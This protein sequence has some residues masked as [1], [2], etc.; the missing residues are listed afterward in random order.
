MTTGTLTQQPVGTPAIPGVVTLI[1][2]YIGL[3]IVDAFA[4]WLIFSL[5]N[6]GIWELAVAIA[7]IT[8][9][10]NV[11]NLRPQLKPL[12]WMSPAFA[13]L[14]LGVIY[15]IVYTV[16]VAFTNYGDGHLLTKVQAVQLLERRT[17][18]PETGVRYSW[19]AFLNEA[20]EY[21]LWLTDRDGNAF[22]V[23]GQGALQPVSGEIPETYQG[24]RRATRAERTRLLTAAANQQFGP[25]D[26]R[27][28]VTRDFAAVLVP[29]YRYDSSTDTITDLQTG[30]VFVANDTIGFFIDKAA[31]EAALAAN[32]DARPNDFLMKIEG[33]PAGVGYRTVIG[34]ANF[35]RFFNSPALR[36]PLL[37]IFTWT[38]VFAF[39][40]VA[41][42]F[43][44]G[45]LVALL[46]QGKFV[47]RRF[48]RTMLIVPYAIPA[49]ISVVTWRGMFQPQFG[50][51][52]QIIPGLPNVFADGTLTRIAILIVNLWLGY[53]YFMLICSGAL[54]AIPADLYEA[55]QVDGANQF[56]AFRFITMPLLLVSIGP[57]LISSF[58]FNFNNYTL[59]AA[60]NDGNPVIA[61]SPIPAGQ[62][63]ILIS[64]TYRVAFSGQG[65]ADFGFASAISIVIFVIVGTVTIMQMGLTRRWE[66][67][68]R[69]V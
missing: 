52:S 63:D 53:P 46:M 56:Q 9:L 7:A 51:F 20:G 14:A 34:F 17:F 4:L 29:R 38:V 18:V 6:D 26:N 43:A 42:T 59:I 25:E 10:V 47:G 40:S 58:T 31:Y 67:V 48:F 30:T 12:R 37:S 15:P 13:L 22:F 32:P 28:S 45:L 19:E 41:S 23:I 68:S 69:N 50:V 44:L 33:F 55:A 36:G 5:I 1:I 8:L 11:I 2:R 62:T 66:E 35:D 60:F 39:S 65:G 21:A 3:M 54:A 16:Y 24:F 61:D 64:Y 27:L 57:L 49:L